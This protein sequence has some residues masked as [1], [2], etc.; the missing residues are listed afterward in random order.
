MDLEGEREYGSGRRDV[1][2]EILPGKCPPLRLAGRVK[3]E[4]VAASSGREGGGGEAAVEGEGLLKDDEDMLQFDLNVSDDDIPP[5]PAG[6]KKKKEDFLAAGDIA[7]G[8]FFTHNVLLPPRIRAH[9]RKEQAYLP[10]TGTTSRVLSMSLFLITN[11]RGQTHCAYHSVF[12]IRLNDQE[13]KPLKGTDRRKAM[14]KVTGVPYAPSKQVDATEENVAKAWP[15]GSGP[16]RY[17]VKPVVNGMRER[18][19][20]TFFRPINGKYY[21]HCGCELEDCLLDLFIWKSSDILVSPS[22]GAREWF[23]AAPDPRHRF[24]FVRFIRALGVNVNNLYAYDDKGVRRDT[25]SACEML[26][27]YLKSQGRTLPVPQPIMPGRVRVPIPYVEVED[28]EEGQIDFEDD[29]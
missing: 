19:L 2:Q 15:Q 26:Q 21:L 27:V 10:E 3:A 20:L 7:L 25:S 17:Q 9:A 18:E 13:E 16:L 29:D 1:E 14:P 12:D 28:G 4:E 6:K 22:T 23:G 24:H 5:T 8:N 11:G